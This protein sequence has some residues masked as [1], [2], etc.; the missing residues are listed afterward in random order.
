MSAV[1]GSA[2]RRFRELVFSDFRRY[3]ID[4]PPSWFRVLTRCMTLPGMVASLI[5]RAQQCL[6][7]SGRVR[8][9]NYLRTVSVILVNADF[10]PGMKIGPGLELAHPIGVSIGFGLT[11]GEGVTFAGGVTCAASSPDPSAAHEFATIE[12]GAILGAHAVLVGGVRIGRHAMVGA[13]SVVLK[14]VPEYAVV[15]GSPARQ[16]GTREATSDVAHL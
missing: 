12:D 10:S 14:D 2:W 16:V 5:L 3:R 9:A 4:K 11:I 8:L 6:Y 1:E 7:D 15:M 13:N